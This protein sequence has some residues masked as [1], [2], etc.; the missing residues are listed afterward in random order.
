MQNEP[1]ENYGNCQRE[2]DGPASINSRNSI[3][4]V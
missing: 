1:W 2:L 3:I 4:T